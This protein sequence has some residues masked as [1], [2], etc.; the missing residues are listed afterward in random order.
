MEMLR[1]RVLSYRRAI[2]VWSGNDKN[3]ANTSAAI[4]DET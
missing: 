4:A 3:L 1:K 2:Y